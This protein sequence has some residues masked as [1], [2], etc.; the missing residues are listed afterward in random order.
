M[1]KFIEGKMKYQHNRFKDAIKILTDSV[2]IE[3][4]KSNDMSF[5]YDVYY[6]RSL[7]YYQC[8]RYEDALADLDICETKLPYGLSNKKYD[9]YFMKA[10]NYYSDGKYKES[11]FYSDKASK[12]E[13]IH[14]E[15]K[16]RAKDF[17]E[18]SKSRL[19]RDAKSDSCVLM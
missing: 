1:D 11:I 16:R 19:D 3:V 8:E 12:V 4:P 15:Q 18:L 7:A 2:N 6:Y 14:E 10:I 5:T 9:T 17:Y 13:N